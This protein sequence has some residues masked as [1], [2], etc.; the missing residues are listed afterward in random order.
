MYVYTERDRD[1]ERQ[2]ERERERERA[3]EIE[4]GGERDITAVRGH[5]QHGT[6]ILASASK[7]AIAF[8]G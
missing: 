2:R 8:W 1:R 6:N 3:R 7:M 5:A 4:R